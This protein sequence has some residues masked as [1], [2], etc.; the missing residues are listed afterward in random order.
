[1]NGVLG[2]ASFFSSGKTTADAGR[3]GKIHF[4]GKPMF[5]KGIKL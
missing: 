3:T 5:G 4:Q 1:M 2:T